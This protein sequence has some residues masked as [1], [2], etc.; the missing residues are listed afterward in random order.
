VKSL[1]W[2]ISLGSGTSGGVLAPLLM[3]G[4]A[5]GGIESLVLPNQGPGFWPLISMG[6]ILGGTMRSPFTGV[7]FA[8]ELTHDINALLPLM[9]A[10]FLA[11]GFT[12]LTLRRSILTEKI[13]RRGYH[14]SREYAIDPLEILFVREAMRT[15]VV[16]LPATAAPADLAR[17][18]R[19]AG[20]DTRERRGQ[21]LYPV[22][23]DSGALRGVVTRRDLHGA[24][25][26]GES[27]PVLGADGTTPTPAELIKVNPVVAHPD[28]P[29]RAIVNRMAETGLT[30]FPVVER[31]DKQRLVGLISLRDLLLA[32]E[33][34][35]AE[36]RDRERVLRVRLFSPA[37]ARQPEHA[38]QR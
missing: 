35:W 14:L 23:D 2:S 9:I 19:A 6:A 4:G 21:H 8:L 37:G 17:S 1:I 27:A 32:R 13:S 34:N 33:R 18:L 3:M 28:E 15:N 25:Q 10:V 20:Q 7:I 16:A 38:A 24:L 29:L 11:H 36:E 12:V 30:Q 26:I 22:V 31:T 5:L